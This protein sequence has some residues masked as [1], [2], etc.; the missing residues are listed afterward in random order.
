[1]EILYTNTR[2]AQE[3]VTASQAILNGLA[4]HGGLYVPMTIP[5]LDVPVE[6]LAEMTYQEVAYEVMSR[7]LT[8]FTPEELKHCIDSAYDSKL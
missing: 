4:G 2:D 3:K 5:K 7:F 6:K 8:D 1:M